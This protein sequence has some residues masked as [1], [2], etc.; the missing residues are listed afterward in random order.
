MVIRAASH[1]DL[2]AIVR[3]FNAGIA[4]GIATFETRA[5]AVDELVP[6]LNIPQHPLLVAEIDTQIAG[7]VVGHAY[8]PRECYASIVEYSI[9]I[10]PHFHGRGV[11]TALMEVFISTCEAQR[12]HKITGKIFA[13]NQAS[14]KLAQRAGFRVVGTHSNHGKID[15]V[16]HDIVVVE[17]VLERNL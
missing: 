16:W 7:W 15:G 6:W 8:S 12:L 4:S 10:D 17:R 13:V 3:I 11:G 1:N 2:V 5:R 9:Y 14:L